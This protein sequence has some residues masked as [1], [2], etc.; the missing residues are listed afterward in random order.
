[1]NHKISPGIL[2]PHI[3][4]IR[5]F[6]SLV[7]RRLPQVHVCFNAVILLC[8]ALGG[9]AP[10]FSQDA[11][12]D[13]AVFVVNS[14]DFSINGRTTANAL[15]YKGELKKGE[16][17]KGRAELEKYVKDK[18]QLL[19]NQR[20]LARVQ[21]EYRVGERRADGK[22]PVDL[23]IITDDSSNL[24]ALPKPE[25]KTDA[26][27]DITLKAR[28]YNFLGSM[29]PLRFDLGYQY[30]EN[31]Q[32]T[33]VFE[34]DSDTPF[35]AFGF[36]WNI[37]FDHFFNYRADAEEPY[38][39][40]NVTGLSM[41]LP[42][43]RTT[44]TFGFEESVILHE[45]NADRYNEQ[46]YDDFQR[47]LYMSSRPYIDWKIPTGIDI[48]DYGELTY[49][50]ELSAAFNHGLP[51]MSL[52]DFRKGPFVL[53]NHSLGFERVNWVEGNNYRK[54]FDVSL[55]NSYTYDF[56]RRRNEQTALSFD[57]A[58]K[59]AGHFIVTGSFG[60]SARLQFRQWFY[61][62][63]DY[64]ESAADVLRGI[65]DKAVHADYML[66]LNLDFPFRVL[67]MRPS[68]WLFN[69]PR[70]DYFDFDLHLSPIIDL[71]LYHDPEA[72]TSFN[73]K[74]MLASGGVEAIVFPIHWRALYL[75]VSLAW[76]FVEQINNPNAY[77]LNPILPIVPHLPGG[78]NREIFIGIGHYY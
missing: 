78:D 10:L 43:K 29:N 20:Q 35:K 73:F 19:Y 5:Q 41:E 70:R 51:G 21:I 1:M 25:Y 65:L 53:W 56:Y 31:K 28:D 39:Y 12:P 15:I 61:H 42:Y 48:G 66:S 71:A 7:W 11:P 33:V 74:N 6:E 14:F 76:N 38:Y 16:E 64:Y 57:Y 68:R 9:T 47:G 46:G 23:R 75:R 55:S 67:Q 17:L 45:E 32:S 50:P 37:N 60:V 26:G 18:Q 22:Y 8:L 77:Y 63:P 30:D 27:L 58:A 13:G 52:E 44:F 62:D 49:T 72:K 40:K 34:I 4:L 24:V 2:K 54:G 3:R 59:A 69:N 36:N